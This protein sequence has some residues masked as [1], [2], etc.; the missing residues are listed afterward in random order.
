LLAYLAGVLDAEGS[1]GIHSNGTGTSVRVMYYNT[2]QELP[3]FTKSALGK[4][5]YSPTGPYLDKRKGTSTS[6]YKIERKKDYYKLALQR[7]EDAKDLIRRLPLLH[8]EKIRRRRLALSIS[9]GQGW[10]TVEPRIQT[11]RAEIRKERDAFV[12]DAEEVYLRGH[13][14]TT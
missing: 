4:L 7:F 12:H 11:L 2:S 1:V 10:N 14:V 3:L 6:K 8:D 9:F 5:G 13:P